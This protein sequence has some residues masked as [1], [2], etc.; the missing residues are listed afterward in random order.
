MTATDS[1]FAH[2]YFHLPNMVLAA[3]IYTLIGRYLLS[4]FFGLDSDKVVMK[5]FRSVTDPVIDIVGA[6][7]PRIVPRGLILIFSIIWLFALRMML[8]IGFALAGLKP[9]IGG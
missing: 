9:G 5:V 2:W 6:I 1:F 7:T 3:L 8:F 4:L